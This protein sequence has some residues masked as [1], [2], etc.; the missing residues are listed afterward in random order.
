MKSNEELSLGLI[1]PEINIESKSSNDNIA[2]P[3]IQTW[4]IDELIDDYNNH[5][6]KTHSNELKKINLEKY[7][8]FILNENKQT[9][10]Y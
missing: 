2:I 4:S 6:E 3:N 1:M 5:S 8:D 7:Q 10:L 9:Y